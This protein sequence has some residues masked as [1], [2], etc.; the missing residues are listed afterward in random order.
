[1]EPRPTIRLDK[2][3]F[4][5]RFFKTRGLSAKLVTAGGVRVNGVR[6]SKPSASVGV[7]DTLTFAQGRA[8]RVVEVRDL[9]TRRGP[10]PEAQAL[11]ADHS[12]P[13]PPR[14]EAAPRPG[15]RPTKKDRRDM[16]AQ[17]LGRTLE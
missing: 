7:G 4:F 8:I 6:V 13:V 11:Y 10:A 12:P 17:G 5:A 2:W 15:A 16:N 9:G 1:L 3:L 14:P